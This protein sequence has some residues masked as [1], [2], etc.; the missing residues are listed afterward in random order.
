[1]L[2]LHA[3]WRHK[4]SRLC[5]IARWLLQLGFVLCTEEGRSWTSCSMFKML[6][7]VWSRGP[8]NMSAVC[9]RWCMTTCTGWLFPS[10]CSTSSLWQSIVVFSTELL[11]GYLAD[12]CVPVSE[13]PGR[14]HLRSARR[15]Q[16]L[17]PRVRRG[18]FGTRAFSVAGPAVW[19]SLPDCLRD[20]AVDSEHF[21]YLF[22]YLF[23]GHS[24][25]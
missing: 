16:L 3:R 14:Q 25:W 1:M 7:H 12:Y 6:Q 17:I 15:H 10:Q 18:T 23:A 11:A 13:V 8:R 5:Y 21:R 19:D 24:R 4:N 9:L 22:R 2:C 20:P